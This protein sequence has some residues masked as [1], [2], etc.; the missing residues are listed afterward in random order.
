MNSQDQIL[1][2]CLLSRS[3]QDDFFKF[4]RTAEPKILDRVTAMAPK[5]NKMSKPRRREKY[6]FNLWSS[7]GNWNIWVT[8]FE[9]TFS[10]ILVSSSISVP[11]PRSWKGFPFSRGDSRTAPLTRIITLRAPTACIQINTPIFATFSYI[12][13]FYSIS[14]R[15]ISIQPATCS[16]QHFTPEPTRTN[17][18][19]RG[20]TCTTS[21]NS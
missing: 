16:R 2:I 3:L 21:S 14:I 11:S 12:P 4:W 1:E 8:G 19:S 7:M 20:S 18:F 10:A 17:P 6:L 5:S 15:P 13:K 9:H